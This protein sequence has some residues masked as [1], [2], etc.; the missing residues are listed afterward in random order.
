M[1]IGEQVTDVD[2]R[3]KLSTLIFGQRTFIGLAVQFIC[4]RGICFRKIE[5]KDTF[6]KRSRHASP[7]E[8]KDLPEYLGV[9]AGP[10]CNLSHLHTQFIANFYPRCLNLTSSRGVREWWRRGGL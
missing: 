2:I 3:I 8:V 1:P 5:H 10:E 4:T 7:R 6:G 9:R